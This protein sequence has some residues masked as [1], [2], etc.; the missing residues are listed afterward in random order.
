MKAATSTASPGDRPL[1][2]RR[3]M[4]VIPNRLYSRTM[5]NGVS[6][7]PRLPVELVLVIKKEA[8]MIHTKRKNGYCF[9]ASP[10]GVNVNPWMASFEST[11]QPTTS[12]LSLT[13]EVN[14]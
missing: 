8:K 4:R 3:N 5:L 7:R 2:R 13:P 10:G 14:V 1:M 6:H 9:A 11:N 12:L